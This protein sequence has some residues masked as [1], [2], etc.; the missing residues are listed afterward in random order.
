MS[1]DEFDAL[2]VIE[3]VI[4]ASAEP[5]PQKSLLQHVP[6]DTD[7]GA[8]LTRLQSDYAGRGVNLLQIGGAWAFRTAA[9]LA[10]RLKIEKVAVRKLSRA[11]VETLAIIAY[12][13]PVRRP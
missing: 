6:E 7:L 2:R 1:L 13:Q 9:D 3:A 8:L 10:G 4:F 5:V 12:H 11:A